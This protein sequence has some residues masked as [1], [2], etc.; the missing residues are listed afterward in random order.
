MKLRKTMA[1]VMA[2]SI[3]CGTPAVMVAYQPCYELTVNASDY[4]DVVVDDAKFAL[5]EDH[6]ELVDIPDNVK[7]EY[8]IPET[9]NG[10]P[11]TRTWAI[12]F[13]NQPELT[14]IHVPASLT[15]L[16]NSGTFRGTT[17]LIKVTVDEDN[18]EYCTLEGV[19][20]SK[21]KK[22]ICALPTADPPTEYVVTDNVEIIGSDVFL[23]YP[24]ESVIMPD[25]VIEI[26]MLAFKDMENLKNVKMSNSL[27]EIGPFT[28]ERDI[29]LES[30]DIPASVEEISR[31]AFGECASLTSITINNPECYISNDETTLGVKGATVIRGY[32]DST[33]QKYAE[34]YGFAFE[35]I[36]GASANTSLGDPTGDGK[37]D[38]KDASFVL[39]E[40]AKLS[41]GGESTLSDA[42]K[43]AADVNKDGKADAKDA[44]TILTYYAY[45]S[46]GGTDTIESYL[47]YGETPVTMTTSDISINTTT[48]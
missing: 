21:D 36:D 39:V 9:V 3:V 12:A 5:Y 48:T 35:A 20:Y 4:E 28:F 6:A 13:A 17:N 37:I 2:C 38:A 16:Y 46:T 24:F 14:S 47:G 27:K 32:S 30:I 25:S 15:D 18:P 23:G 19:L 34:T 22:T 33:A 8:S 29:A 1:A 42:E 45:V 11:V 43:N 7:G 44:S 41:T 10:L 26:K 40:Y 31:C